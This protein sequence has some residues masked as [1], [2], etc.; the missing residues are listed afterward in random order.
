MMKGRYLWCRG[1][2]LLLEKQKVVMSG[3]VIIFSSLLV[4]LVERCVNW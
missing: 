2:V 4:Q 1:H 3:F